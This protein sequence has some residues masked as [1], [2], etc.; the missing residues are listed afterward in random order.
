MLLGV[1]S[2]ARWLPGPSLALVGHTLILPN[3]Q[4]RST[5]LANTCGMSRLKTLES[6]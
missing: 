1:T 5:E 6:F 2:I 4:K 3:L